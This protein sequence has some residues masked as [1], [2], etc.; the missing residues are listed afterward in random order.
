MPNEFLME[1]DPWMNE[2]VE[3]EPVKTYELTLSDGSKISDLSLNGNNFVSKT[4]VT[5]DMFK[6]KLSTVL[7]TDD[8]GGSMQLENAELLQIA[9]YPDMEGWFFI[10]RE[11]PEEILFKRKVMGDL[12]YLAMMT[13]V[14][15]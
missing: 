5:E 14:E 1:N 7:I 11:T 13:D 3:P 9:T 6:G 10:I 12:D 8:Y 4:E 15:I 2:T